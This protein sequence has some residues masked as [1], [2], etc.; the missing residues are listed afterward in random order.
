MKKRFSLVFFLCSFFM[1]EVG[2]SAAD[3]VF[4]TADAAFTAR[5]CLQA[6]DLYRD[7]VVN[8]KETSTAARALL[9]VAKSEYCLKNYYES[10]LD[11]K[12]FLKMYPDSPF[13]GDAHLLW[14]QVLLNIQR[15]KEAEEQFD[16]V[17]G[18][19][20]DKAL[21]GKAELAFIRGEAEK[22]ENLLSKID[23]KTY[24]ENNRVLY[25]RAMVLSRQGKHDQAIKTINKIPD[26]ALKEENIVVS[27]AIIYYNAS[28]FAEA[29]KML[30]SV[31]SSSPSRV[32]EISAKRTL[33]K[34][35]EI[36]N[37]VDDALRIAL[38]LLNYD[39]G[40]DLKM[41]LISIYDKKRDLDNAFRYIS[42]LRDPN[43]RSGELEKKF[44]KLIAEKD[45]KA[46]EY[47]TKYFMSLGADSPYAVELAKYLDEKGNR[48]LAERLL[49]KASRG[50]NRAEASFALAELLI[51]DKRYSEAGKV[52]TPLTTETRYSGQASLLLYQ[53][54]EK[55]GKIA[56]AAEYRSK[57]IKV[58]EIQKDYLRVGD[59]YVRSGNHGEALKYY[60]KASEKGENAAIVKA[61]DMYYL[62]GKFDQAKA[63][64]KKALVRGVKDM[65]SADL[66]WA[67]YQYGKMTG[68]DEYLK[69]AESGGGATAQAA[70]A[71]MKGQ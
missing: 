29:K 24:E 59:L 46:D 41:K 32:D 27:K 15:Y 61:A 71:M 57:A 50:R 9:G 69:R 65:D 6:K 36:E 52:I 70:G 12:R 1:L 8:S 31:M 67:N 40:D 56:E 54:L 48:Q 14:G 55:E 58:L 60:I 33:M 18:P 30:T 49:Q 43:I 20:Q 37:S 35:Y 28:K 4:F 3:N 2:A 34:I 11:L 5:Q 64:Y 22:T 19:L 51:K 44:K 10:G 23:R 21:I 16:R 42:Y 66:Q 68:N 26:Q 38:D 7:I 25:L 13:A 63:Y 17:K 62:L 39:S 47:I 53:V 45:P